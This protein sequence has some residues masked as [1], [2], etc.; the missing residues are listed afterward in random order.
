MINKAGLKM[1]LVVDTSVVVASIL[2]PGATRNLLFNPFLKLYSP[3]RLEYEIVKNKEKFKEYVN[4][5]EE[6]F[7]EALTLALKQ[8]EIIPFEEYEKNEYESKE[9]CKRDESD[10]PFVALA[11]KLNIGIW[12]TDP[13]LLKGQNKVNVISTS[14][15]LKIITK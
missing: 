7:Q 13:D 12:S 1:E 9:L 4:F 15:L 2:R 10:W 3:E 14:E 11:L 8:I 5:T 6:Q